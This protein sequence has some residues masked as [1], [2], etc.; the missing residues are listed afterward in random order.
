[1]TVSQTSLSDIAPPLPPPP[2][3]WLLPQPQQSDASPAAAPHVAAEEM[4]PVSIE[5]S[6]P[7]VF[8]GL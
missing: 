4:P 1:M 8:P 7:R 5:T 6:W 2:L 3:P